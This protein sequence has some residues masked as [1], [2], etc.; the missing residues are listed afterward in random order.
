MFDEKKLRN[1]KLRKFKNIEK[2]VPFF[3]KLSKVI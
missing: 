2:V 1:R 3:K